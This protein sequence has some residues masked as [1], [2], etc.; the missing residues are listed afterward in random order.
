MKRDG[1]ILKK[2]NLENKRYRCQ[3]R[4]IRGY[5]VKEGKGNLGRK[6]NWGMWLHFNS[7]EKS[8]G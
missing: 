3:W 2:K 4:S 8:I 5:R 1:V 7:R 6:G